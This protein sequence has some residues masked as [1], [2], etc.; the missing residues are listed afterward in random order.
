MSGSGDMHSELVAL[1]L[2]DH[3]E[4]KRLLERFGSLP[5]SQRDDAFCELTYELVRHEVAEEEV[6]YP[7]LRRYVDGGDDIADMRI[8]EQSTAEQLLADMEK[9]GVE[10]PEFASMFSTLRT[11]VLAHA[12]AEERTVFPELSSC[13]GADELRQLGKRYELAKKAAPT[14]P[15]PHAPDTPPGNLVLGP[16]AA[17][18]DRVRDAVRG[19]RT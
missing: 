19:V 15:H 18:V 7:A 16:V 14:H 1:L 12:E 8:A 3:Q 2:A 13:I 11:D 6:V 9:A 17:V 10:S 4:A 5:A